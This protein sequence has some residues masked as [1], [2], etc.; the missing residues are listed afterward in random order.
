MGTTDAGCLMAQF[1]I[2]HAQLQPH[3]FSIR[4]TVGYEIDDNFLLYDYHVEYL[5]SAETIYRQQE[6]SEGS[7]TT[8]RCSYRL[9]YNQEFR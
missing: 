1:K 2:L 4:Q 3:S 5:R 7:F 9:L 8:G 6:F